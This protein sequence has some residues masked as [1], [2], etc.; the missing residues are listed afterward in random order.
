MTEI[1][2]L[3]GV[4]V[5]TSYDDLSGGAPEQFKNRVL[6]LLGCAIGAMGAEPVQLVHDEV[7]E[8]GPSGACTLI[9]GGRTAPDRAA[10]YNGALVRYLDYNDGYVAKGESG[11]P[12]ANP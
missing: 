7:A 4:V 5:R 3:G 2:R 11:H 1:E 8:F 6:R 12:R 9:G 10:F